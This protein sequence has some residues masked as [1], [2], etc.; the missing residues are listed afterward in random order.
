MASLPVGAIVMRFFASNP[1]KYHMTGAKKTMNIAD[2]VKMDFD[3][4]FPRR[5]Q[6]RR[7]HGAIPLML[8]RG[9]LL[10]AHQV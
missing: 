4:L 6:R 8:A 1:G 5:V 2:K 10:P 9:N 3:L 7:G